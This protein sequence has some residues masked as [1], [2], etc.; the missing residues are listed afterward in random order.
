MENSTETEC[1]L[2]FACFQR[3]PLLRL[4]LSNLFQTIDVI[5]IIIIVIITNII[6]VF[7]IIIIV[8][9]IIV[10]INNITVVLF[11]SHMHFLNYAVAIIVITSIKLITFT[12][13]SLIHN[14]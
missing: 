10:I 5:I 12:F 13:F 9:I 2:N 11:T 14:F 3:V 8:F 1:G 7:I 4:S 6:F